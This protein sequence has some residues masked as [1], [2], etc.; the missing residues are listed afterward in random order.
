MSYKLLALSAEPKVDSRHRSSLIRSVLWLSL[1]LSLVGFFAACLLLFDSPE[2]WFT[3]PASVYVALVIGVVECIWRLP[4]ILARKYKASLELKDLVSLENNYRTLLLQATGG[5]L[6]LAGL[7]FTAQSLSV[8]QQNVTLSLRRDASERI[9]R[10]TSRL[11]DD[12]LEARLTAIYTIE[13][14]APESYENYRLAME[15]L[16]SFVRS[17]A[18][19]TERNLQSEESRELGKDV[20]AVIRFLGE[21]N[22]YIDIPKLLPTAQSWQ[23]IS[24]DL[25]STDL[26]EVLLIGTYCDGW[27]LTKA[28]LDRANLSRSKIVGFDLRDSNLQN[29]NLQETIFLGCDLTNANLSGANLKNAAFGSSS[30]LRGT[31][32]KG[33]DIEGADLTGATCL[34]AEQIRETRNYQLAKL[35]LD[36]TA[37]LR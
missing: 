12:N 13:S 29:A 2:H 15:I 16:P 7:Y 28:H 26:R 8:S 5:I 35:P 9:E 24:I 18:P 27:L 32:L 14:V 10:A 4:Q 33:A 1:I 23:G 37:A 22:E 20:Q 19:W 30:C 31:F 36:L 21:H 34:T 25:R 3:A 11:K 17:R 6:L